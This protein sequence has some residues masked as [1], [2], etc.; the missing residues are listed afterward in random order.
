PATVWAGATVPLNEGRTDA[1][2]L[3]ATDSPLYAELARHGVRVCGDVVDSNLRRRSAL[4][5]P[6][7]A[8]YLPACRSGS[9][10][11]GLQQGV[12][13]LD[14]ESAGDPEALGRSLRHLVVE[15]PN[16]PTTVLI[17]APTPSP[18]MRS[19][20]GEVSPSWRSSW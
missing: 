6:F 10:R 3:K 12:E 20:G 18:E 5:G 8:R 19:S 9:G 16:V 17:V 15:G 4:A 1:A 2:I 14:A 13:V 11:L 7:A